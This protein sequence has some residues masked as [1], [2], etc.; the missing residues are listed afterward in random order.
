[1]VIK[2]D[3]TDIDR[4]AK[5]FDALGSRARLQIVL[6]LVERGN[7]GLS[8]GDIQSRV[9]IAPSTLAHHLRFLT[10][11]GLVVQEKTGRT[12]INKAAFDHLEDLAAFILKRCCIEESAKDE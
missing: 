10:A 1:M 7:A 9:G 12:I 4:A 8:I 5:G 6:T 11:A 2:N 3:I